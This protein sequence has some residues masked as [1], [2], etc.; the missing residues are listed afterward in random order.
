[1][2]DDIAMEAANE[3]V[4]VILAFMAGVI[5]AAVIGIPVSMFIGAAWG[6]VVGIVI[7]IVITLKVHKS[8]SE[9]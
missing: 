8:L 7:C 4:R 6:A 1:M 2:A 3:F 9:E 5:M